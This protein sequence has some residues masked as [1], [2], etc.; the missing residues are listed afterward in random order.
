[1]PSSVAVLK[2][3]KHAKLKEANLFMKISNHPSIVSFFGLC[4]ED[5]ER[6]LVTEYSEHGSVNDA[7]ERFEDD[8]TMQH[9]LVIVQ[10]AC[11][12]MSYLSDSSLLHGNLQARNILL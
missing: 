4:Y 5:N 9:K 11:S 2:L 10:Q 1:M 6:Y 3:S 7:M 8:F 12:A